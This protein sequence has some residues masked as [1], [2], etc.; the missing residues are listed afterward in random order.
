MMEVRRTLHAKP[1]GASKMLAA[2][3][4]QQGGRQER[5]IGK[6][7]EGGRCRCLKNRKRAPKF[8]I[9][10]FCRTSGHELHEVHFEPGGR[11]APPAAA[12]AGEEAHPGVDLAVVYGLNLLCANTFCRKSVKMAKNYELGKNCP[13]PFLP[14]ASF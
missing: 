6:R 9:D 3:P 4:G 14:E 7:A 8:K 13:N 12:E 1:L 11:D 10:F 2:H 5:I